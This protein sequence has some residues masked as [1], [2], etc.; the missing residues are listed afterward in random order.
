[1]RKSIFNPGFNTVG[2]IRTPGQ[3]PQLLLPRDRLRVRFDQSGMSE[4]TRPPK[5]IG[6]PVFPSGEHVCRRLEDV[7]EGLGFV[8]E[9]QRRLKQKLQEWQNEP[10]IL[11]FRK[12]VMR[13]LRSF[14]PDNYMLRSELS[15]RAMEFYKATKGGRFDRRP[16]YE[17][18]VLQKAEEFGPGTYEHHSQRAMDHTQA[19]LAHAKAA[20]SAQTKEEAS[21]H[22]SKVK[23]AQKASEEAV[24]K[25]A[26]GKQARQTGGNAR[27]ENDGA[28][29]GNPADQSKIEALLAEEIIKRYGVD[30]AKKMLEE[31]KSRGKLN[32]SG[33]EALEL[34]E[35][36]EQLGLFG[37]RPAA[38]PKAAKKP[39]LKTKAPSG[40]LGKKKGVIGEIR[41]WKGGRYQKQA[42]GQ[43]KLVSEKKEGKEK[44]V[45]ADWGL[46]DVMPQIK[47]EMG[48][49]LDQPFAG[50]DMKAGI[51]WALDNLPKYKKRS[52]FLNKLSDVHNQVKSFASMVKQRKQLE[53]D[54]GFWEGAALVGAAAVKIA[55]GLAGKETKP[56]KKEKPSVK[57]PKAEDPSGAVSRLVVPTDRGKGKVVES[58][59]AKEKGARLKEVVE[60]SIK[61]PKA[62]PDFIF[63]GKP[64]IQPPDKN[65]AIALAPDLWPKIRPESKLSKDVSYFPNPAPLK[66]S[67]GNITGYIKNLFYHQVEGAERI[68]QAWKDGDGCIL[69]DSAGLGKTLTSLAVMKAQGGKRNLIVVPTAGKEGLKAQW[70][71]PTGGQLYN[72][73]IKGAEVVTDKK[74]KDKLRHRYDQLSATEEGTYIVSYDE[75]YQVVKDPETGKP[76]HPRRVEFRPDIFGGR[77]DTVM[78]DES[79][80]MVNPKSKTSEAGKLLMGMADKVLYM[81]A[82]PFTNISDMQYLTKLNLFDEFKVNEEGEKVDEEAAFVAWA[83]EAGAIVKERRYKQSK[84]PDIVEPGR[85]QDVKNPASHIPMAAIA[86]TLHVDGKSI[87]RSTSL[88]GVTSKFG[89][90]DK[91]ELL[92]IHRAAF[93]QVE[94]IL[95]YAK[96]AAGTPDMILRALYIGWNR[97]YW[98]TLKVDKAIELGKKALAEGKQVAFF[99]SFKASNH[100]H[101]RAIPRM[102][103]RNALKLQ[104]NEKTEALGRQ[105]ETVA[106]RLNE[107]CEELPEGESAVQRLAEA[108]G[109]PEKVAEIHGDTKKK[110]HVEQNDYQAGKKKVCVATMARGGTGISLHD[111]T[112]ESPRVQI[113]LSLPWSGREFNQVAGRSHRLGSKSDTEMHWL[114]GDD[115]HEEHNAAVVARRLKSMGSLTTGDPE[116][117][118][119]ATSLANFDFGQAQETDDAKDLIKGFEAAAEANSEDHAMTIAG[120]RA[121]ETA[122]RRGEKKEAG[123]AAAEEAAAARD[124]FRE[125]AEQRKGGLNVIKERY[126]QAQTRKA[127]E[128]FLGARRAAE[129]LRQKRGWEIK[130]RPGLQAFEIDAGLARSVADVIKSKKVG[131]QGKTYGTKSTLSFWVPPEGMQALAERLN[132]HEHKIDMRQAADEH[133]DPKTRS[134][135]EFMIDELAHKHL[136]VDA[137][138]DGETFYITGQTYK[139]FQKGVFRGIARGQR[140]GGQYTYIVSKDNLPE[141]VERM[142]GALTEEGVKA[143]RA[144]EAKREAEAKK[145]EAKRK[146]MGLPKLQGSDKQVSWANAIREKALKAIKNEPNKDRAERAMAWLNRQKRASAIIDARRSIGYFGDPISYSFDDIRKSDWDRE[147]ERLR[148]RLMLRRSSHPLELVWCAEEI[149]DELHESAPQ[150]MAPGW[151]ANDQMVKGATHKYIKR[152]PTG[153]PKP[154]YRY[155]YRVPGKKGLV[156]SEDLAEGS[157]FKAEHQGSK[158]HFEVRQ[159][160]KDKGIVSVRH[161]ESGRTIHMKEKDLHRM[162]QKQVAKKTRAELAGEVK[163]KKEKEKDKAKAKKPVKLKIKKEVKSKIKSKKEKIKPK[164]DKEFPKPEK[165]KKAAPRLR[166]VSMDSLGKGGYDSIEGF[167]QTP[168][169]LERQVQAMG[170]KDREFAVIPQANGYVLAS[171]SKAPIGSSKIVGDKT[172]IFIRGSKG[173]NIQS[174]DADYEIVDAGSLIASHDPNSFAERKE[175][176]QGVQE[177]RYHEVEG[178]RNKIIRIAQELEPAMMLNTNPDAINGAPIVTEDHIVLGGNG[179]TMGMQ[180]AYKNYPESAE[181]LKK[182]MA[183]HAKAFGATAAQVEAM[184]QPILVRR[185]KVGKDTDKL[186]ALGRRM[187]EPLMQGLDP[188]SAE[189]ALGK[190]YVT[191]EVVESLTHHMDPDES[192]S[193]FLRSEKSREFMKTLERS[194][195]IDQYNVSEYVNDDNKLLNEDG[196]LRV[197]RVLAARLLPDASLLGEM[198]QKLR[199]NIAK[200]AVFIMNAEGNK[201]DLRTPL[202]TAVKVDREMRSKGFKPNEGGRRDVMKQIEQKGFEGEISKL[203]KD[204]VAQKLLEIIQDKNGPRIMLNGFKQFALEAARQ[205]HDFGANKTLFAMEPVSQDQA[206]TSAFSL[207]KPKVKPTRKQAPM[208]QPSLLAM[209]LRGFKDRLQKGEIAPENVAAYTMHAVNWELDRLM[210]Q[211]VRTASVDAKDIDGQKV[212]AD[213]RSFIVEQAYQDKDF[214]R[215]MGALPLDTKVLEGLVQ[216]HAKANVADISKALAKAGLELAYMKAVA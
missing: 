41:E 131:G 70:I 50:V 124:W 93:N 99:T 40:G 72:I 128:A 87:K 112:G 88:E 196:R 183:Q 170:K 29:K 5:D 115:E 145:A 22:Q 130:W 10:D 190:N 80:N 81:S 182:Y 117:T 118:V 208:E 106:H 129:Q 2:S 27:A 147:L 11:S 152:V 174:L 73:D 107:M 28:S 166:R 55:D 90:T 4:L 141:L 158:G 193:E 139:P 30:R 137:H 64:D 188:R 146:D 15:R 18:Q 194:G 67:K 14:V 156:S 176:P 1:M 153:K 79:H 77:W 184:G 135:A 155:Y 132:V 63:E 148:P 8:Y 49:I 191:P 171:K 56:K 138:P 215:G 186:R 59:E 209:S 119:E 97:Q 195:I 103:M 21:K 42:D 76:V 98:E 202:M 161:D 34:L 201:W 159:Y 179:R 126:K 62:G 39:V 12:S 178:D 212:L 47:K 96:E 44:Q 48:P 52:A 69:Q 104:E 86:A 134:A 13:D 108:F 23:A 143:K 78:F 127:K 180:H 122:K 94:D 74:G 33:H 105:L 173:K 157:K 31:L 168:E 89:V 82:T 187:N 149:P 177:R 125:F 164:L 111:T 84:G 198:S 204:P 66:D 151:P 163:S 200:S 68:L 24:G 32:K 9:D 181:K 110:P 57:K 85:Y 185:V 65:P 25:P 206:L 53:G 123:K 19:A 114:I 216:A 37:P 6:R 109:G 175:Y 7:Y 169:E 60:E 95:Q 142:G 189:V 120:M 210:R 101:I 144:A 36:A 136:K 214:A 16:G 140:M 71:G 172:Q 133:L 35:K 46:D 3:G 75:L 197:E 61:Q 207:D 51:K 38:K 113:N 91:S 83:R 45:A 199:Q 162:M 211:A 116:I 121:E 203:Q 100:E 102:V 205:Q 150:R 20:G 165:P 43:W 167:A 17:G 192:L 54:S 92:P 154:K 213:L 26:N 58:D 160:H